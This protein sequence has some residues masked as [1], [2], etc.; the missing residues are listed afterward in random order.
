MNRIRQKRS[1]RVKRKRH[2]LPEFDSS[3]EGFVYL[4]AREII[5]IEFDT[6]ES[7]DTKN[8]DD[9]TAPNEQEN[10]SINSTNSAIFHILNF[11]PKCERR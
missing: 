2:Y 9:F 1:H 3:E 8:S 11:D 4:P 7:R 6:E 5:H 10:D